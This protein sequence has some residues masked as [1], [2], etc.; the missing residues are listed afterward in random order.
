[1]QKKIFPGVPH[2]L[3]VL[4]LSL[5]IAAGCG[6]NKSSSGSASGGGTATAKDSTIVIAISSDADNLNPLVATSKVSEF[7]INLLYPSLAK[8]SFDTAVGVLTY[9]PW[10]ASSWK[11]A[12]DGKSITYTL[13]SGAKWDDGTAITSADVKF[14]NELIGDT[15]TRSVLQNYLAPLVGA[16]KGAVDFAKAIL[17]PDDSTVIFNFS[18]PLSE[19][20]ALNATS[21]SILPKHI[22]EKVPRAEMRTAAAGA[23]PVGAGPYKLSKWERQQQLV[24]AS[25]AAYSLGTAGATPR[26]VFQVVPDYTVRLTQLKTG[27]V[28]VIG[29]KV[30][31]MANLA[32]ENPGIEAKPVPGTTYTYVGWTNIDPQAFKQSN[33]KTVKPHPLFGSKKVRQALTYAIDR[34]SIMDGFVGRYGTAMTAPIPPI[35]KWAYN[36]SLKPYPFDAA[37]AKAMLAEEGWVTGPDGILQKGGKKF[38]FALTVDRSSNYATT[39]IQQNLKDIGIE[40]KIEQAEQVAFNS[41][42][43]GHEYDAI[44]A[45]NNPLPEVDPAPFWSSDLKQ[46]TYN[47]VGFQNKRVDELIALGGKEASREK[48]A[49]YWKEFQQIIYDE[50]PCTFLYWQTTTVFGFNRRIEGEEVNIISPFYNIEEWRL[51]PAGGKPITKK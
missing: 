39:V 49:P 21:V 46:S 9:K 32:K 16:D 31:D 41:K 45:A 1:M 6:G 2:A 47:D 11:L 17:T 5:A 30:E 24:L 37:K 34:Q 38:S 8:P 15:A 10:L 3:S 7:I 14:T 50:Q 26:V 33:G 29:V 23:M 48:A 13:K 12:T 43:F 19:G 20:T 51:V 27:A 44:Y 25:N 42:R 4:M 28:D 22:W 18:Q 36:D 35:L 40:C